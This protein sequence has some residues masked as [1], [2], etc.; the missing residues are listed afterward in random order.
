MSFLPMGEELA[1]GAYPQMPYEH[2]A[3]EAFEV[4]LA[5]VKPVDWTAAYASGREA[6][7]ERYCSTDHCEIPL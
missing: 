3:P 1:G 2:I 4:M 5:A 6:E 7:G